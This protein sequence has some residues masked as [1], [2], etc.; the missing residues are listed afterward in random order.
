MSIRVATQGGETTQ[1]DYVKGMTLEDV[2]KAAEIRPTKT[3]TVT[4]NGEDADS[5]TPVSDDDVVVLTPK[6]SNG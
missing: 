5:N 3:A 4:V 2:Y 1:V 6:V